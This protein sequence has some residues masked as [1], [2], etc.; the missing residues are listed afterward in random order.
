MERLKNINRK[1]QNKNVPIIL[2]VV[3]NLSTSA[4]SV[5]VLYFHTFF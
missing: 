4:E 1:I 2:G 3:T 5:N